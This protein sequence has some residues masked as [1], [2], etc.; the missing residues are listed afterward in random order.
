MP[1]N[2]V[3]TELMAVL[4]STVCPTRF[5]IFAWPL[6]WPVSWPP[7]FAVPLSDCE[8]LVEKKTF[9]GIVLPVNIP[10]FDECLSLSPYN[11]SELWESVMH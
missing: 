10:S 7:Y 4:C 9:G 5:V 8:A 2:R 3:V 11:D 1:P 6:I